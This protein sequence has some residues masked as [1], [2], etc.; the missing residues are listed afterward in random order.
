MK[1][2]LLNED[3][4]AHK[5]LKDNVVDITDAERSKIMSAKAVW[6]H[7]KDGNATPAIKKS[8]VRG[9]T[10]YWSATHRCFMSAETLA[11]AIKDFFKTVKPSS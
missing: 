7:G 9:K 8:V 11:K 6:H 4:P 5:V 2:S 3:F 10:Y 1:L